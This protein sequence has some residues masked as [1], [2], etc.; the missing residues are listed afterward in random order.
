MVDKV[1]LGQFVSK[2]LG[3]SCQVSFHQM[4]NTY[5]RHSSSGVGTI[6]P[7]AAD[8]PSGLSFTP[9]K[10]TKETSFEWKLIPKQSVSQ[11]V[12][13]SVIQPIEVPSPNNRA[14]LN[15]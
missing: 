5:H 6:A 7:I 14:L 13:Q 1:A 12:S 9:P 3:F 8:V 10:G 11:S 2:Y 15:N 4:L